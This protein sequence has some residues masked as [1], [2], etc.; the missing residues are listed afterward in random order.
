MT[1]GMMMMMMMMMIIIIII[2]IMC[3]DSVVGIATHYGL[4]GLRIESRGDEFFRTCPDRPWGPP[5]LLYNRYQVTFPRVKRLDR[6]VDHPH[7]VATTLKK[8]WSYASSSP[9][10]L[11]SP[12]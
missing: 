5:S 9:L 6:G 2:I 7:H 4:D 10:G 11:H 8:V 1:M 3:R 12:L